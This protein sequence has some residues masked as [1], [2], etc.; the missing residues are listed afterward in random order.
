MQQTNMDIFQS[1]ISYT[2]LPVRFRLC[3]NLSHD[4]D[5]W[6]CSHPPVVRP[7]DGAVRGMYR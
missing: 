3:V 4:V 5:R 1:D 2:P 7:L 6:S